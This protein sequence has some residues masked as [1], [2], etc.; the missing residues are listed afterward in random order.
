MLA[1][2]STPGFTASA[3]LNYTPE[4]VVKIVIN[5]P[6]VDVQFGLLN[7]IIL[8]EICNLLADFNILSSDFM[9]FA[10]YFQLTSLD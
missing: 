7:F 8:I 10:G 5:E 6:L 2:T 9:A 4:C 3:C 1:T